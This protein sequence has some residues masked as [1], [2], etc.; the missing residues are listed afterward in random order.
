[1]KSYLT[2]SV[3]GWPVKGI[4]GTIW[5]IG[6]SRNNGY[7]YLD[8]QYPSDGSIAVSIQPSGAGTTASPY[9]IATFSNLNW[10]TQDASRWSMAYKQ[11]ANID[12]LQSS[13]L[14]GSAGFSP[15]G[16]GTTAFTGS[17]DG[18]TFKIT[19]LFISRNA[20][21]YIGLFGY[22]SGDTIKNVKLDSV[23]ITGNNFVGGLIGYQNSSAAVN[24]YSNGLVSGLGTS[25][26]FVGG[27]IGDQ[28]SSTATNCYSS[29]SVTGTS[30]DGGLIG[31]Q[32]SSSK[33]M[34]CY[35][36]DSVKGD[37]YVGGL[38]G[39][40]IFSTA[41]N[42]YSAGLVTSAKYMGG[43][44]GYALGLSTAANCFWDTTS[45]GQKIS[46][47][48]TGKSTNEMKNYLTFTG[49]SFKGI[50]GDT[51][52]N[53][54]H[55]RNN[56][57][58][59]LNWQFPGDT[60]VTSVRTNS[61]DLVPRVLSLKQNYP[62]PFN[63]TTTIEFTVPEDGRVMLKIFDMLGRE[64]AIAYDGYVKAGYLQRAVFNAS[65]LSSG[66]YFSRLQYKDKSLLKKLILLK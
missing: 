21:D 55:S 61:Q 57:Y 33:V 41:M 39:G 15:I 24:C 48:G 50:G 16:D 28:T 13:L 17:Y 45:S 43:F 7:P 40:Q 1:M 38:I 3:R 64:V 63:P 6:N 62:N 18:Q 25:N 49:W 30:Y 10:I 11:T 22:V 42:C 12:A 31:A 14:D 19:N 20:K 9:L 52:W 32:E 34:N 51:I 66:V 56:G 27:L 23:K 35:S 58:P 5:N 37:S 46:A 65:R 60:I 2:F 26:G 53:I 54:G 44:I 4:N 36:T 8:W 47:G 59:Y 29:G